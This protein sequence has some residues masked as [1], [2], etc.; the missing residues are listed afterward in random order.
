MQY[1]PAN[2]SKVYESFR[3]P[4]GYYTA[5][6]VLLLGTVVNSAQVAKADWPKTAKDFLKSEFKGGKLVIVHPNMDDFVLFY[7]KQVS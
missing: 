5:N 2:W 7:F 3:D 6:L 1:K 4:D